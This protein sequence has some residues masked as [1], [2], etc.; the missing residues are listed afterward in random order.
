MSLISTINGFLHNKMVRNGALFSIYSFFEKGCNF[1]ML[2]ILAKFIAP[3]DYGRLSLFI[4]V[5]TFFGYVVSLSTDGYLSVSF[6]RDDKPEFRRVFTAIL[7]ITASTSLLLL[8]T[9]LP[10][11]AQLA[12]Y[13]KLPPAL[14]YLA[15]IVAASR[16][17]LGILLNYLRVQERVGLYGVFACS[18]AVFYA[19]MAVCMVV[20]L[21]LGW[22]GVVYAQVLVPA[23]FALVAVGCFAA[24]R[25]FDFSD[26]AWSRL[27]GMLLW[28]IPL[29]PHMA[30][31]WL[32]QGAD[33]YI[34]EANHD[35]ASVGL[36]SFA[37]TL[38]GIII[39]VGTAFNN[40]FSVNIFQTLSSPLSA[41]EKLTTL[42]R[43]TRRITW[44]Y[45]LATLLIAL[46]I[47]LIVPLAL[48]RYEGA[49][50]Y[51]LILC[52]YGFLQ[53]IYFQYCNYLFYYKRTRQ[54]MYITF[55][56]ALLH[57]AI[58]F[59][60]TPLSLYLTCLTYVFIQGLIVWLVYRMAQPFV[61]EGDNEK[62]EKKGASRLCFATT[63][64]AF[65]LYVAHATE[66]ELRATFFVFGFSFPRSVA[67]RVPHSYQLPPIKREGPTF[68]WLNWAR[69]RWDFLCHVPRL[70]DNTQIFVQ[71]HP[72]AAAILIGRRPYTFI[73][74]S[75][76]VLSNVYQ[77][78]VE[79]EKMQALRQKWYYPLHRILYGP[80]LHRSWALNRQCRHLL[81]TAIDPHPLLSD[82][83]QTLVPPLDHALWQTFSPQKQQFLLRAFD[84]T[85]AD[86]Q[87]L[88]RYDNILLTQPL[89][90]DILS[91]EDHRAVYQKILDSYPEGSVIIKTHPREHFPYATEFPSVPVFEKVIPCEIF[92]LLG[93]RFH[94]VIT[95]FSTAVNQFDDSTA[96]DWWGRANL[97]PA[98]A[99]YASIAAPQRA[100]IM[101]D[102]TTPRTPVA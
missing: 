76:R 37:I 5:M 48:P 25:L 72:L 40:T 95:V 63:V 64:Y 83:E 35:M 13:A 68:R 88:L 101:G 61:R 20:P 26:F 59:L 2:I 36:F 18:N 16:I 42:R 14:I 44:V 34:I 49:L 65:L 6:F 41:A 50:P 93:V 31:I 77:R 47:C 74:D 58:N 9:I 62:R 7:S 1:L 82:R 24:W 102:D 69:Y 51:F 73:E 55:S 71:D 90:T 17:L 99:R 23:L 87:T 86:V 8:L 91:Y 46:F 79:V 15:V 30:A 39:M 84:L 28:S 29:I 67:Q 12:S 32:R 75:Q 80:T 43:Q 10:F 85:E 89:W 38:T 97:H 54:L 11:D 53:C 52:G 22:M 92:N 4:T 70:T 96:I 33:R 57:V 21:R 94:R 19:L 3:D 56:T 78:Q 98:L 45:V 100:R 66:E 81:V 27:R 60:L